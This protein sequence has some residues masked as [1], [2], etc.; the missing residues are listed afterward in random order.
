MKKMTINDKV[1]WL[2]FLLYTVTFGVNYVT[3]RNIALVP[4]IM[5]MIALIFCIVFLRKL[6]S[7]Y[8]IGIVAFA[9]F[10][11]F[12]GTMLN[13]YSIIP[14]YDI[15]LHFASGILLVL[16]GHYIFQWFV[17][18][19]CTL[20]LKVTILVCILL[21]IAAAAFW[22]I[23]EFTGDSL[24]GLDSQGVAISD[25]MSDIIAGTIGAFIGGY[26]LWIVLKK[27]VKE[28]KK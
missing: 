11:L 19:E 9:G 25:T 10:S 14:I 26:V 16:L 22:E 1:S 20:P 21:S 28:A 12:F 23:W 7:I 24:L 15:L 5:C 8:Y 13:L 6:N 18:N 17:R 3:I 2:L 27:R 4:F